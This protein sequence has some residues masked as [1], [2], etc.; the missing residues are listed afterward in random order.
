[1][2]NLL[3]MTLIILIIMLLY[4]MAYLKAKLD[5]LK[6][7]KRFHWFHDFYFYFNGE[8]SMG[9]IP[10]L[11]HDKYEDLTLDKIRLDRNRVVKYFWIVLVLCFTLPLCLKYLG[12]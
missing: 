3:A 5:I 2:A 10:V 4:R 9:F 8:S 1:M 12:L 7:G 11:D 6:E